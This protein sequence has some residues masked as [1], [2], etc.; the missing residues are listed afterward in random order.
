MPVSNFI[1]TNYSSNGSI[2]LPGNAQNVEV[3][4]WGSKGANGA[5]S[6]GSGGSGRYM[7]VTLPNYTARTLSFN[8]DKNGGSGGNG[9][10]WSETIAV[11]S[12]CN[13]TSNISANW[14]SNGVLKVNGAGNANI[15]INQSTNDSPNTAG[16]SFTNAS[17]NSNFNSSSANFTFN[18]GNFSDSAR[19]QSGDVQFNIQGL[20]KPLQRFN[21]NQ[22]LKLRDGDGNDTNTSFCIG[23]INQKTYS[24]DCSY[25]VTNNYSGYDGGQGGKSA[26]LGDSIAGDYIA[27][28]GGGGGGGGGNSKGG[29]GGN[30]SNAGAPGNSNI[31]QNINGDGNGGSNSAYGGGGG[32]GAGISPGGAG[33][34]GGSPSPTGG[35]GGTGGSSAYD[36]SYC[37]LSTHNTTNQANPKATLKYKLITP[38]INS[39]SVNKTTMINNGTDSITLKWQTTDAIDVDLKGNS[40]DPVYGNSYVD[41]AVDNTSG[42]V[43]Q[44]T[45]DITY[46]LR[47]CSYGNVCTTA[48]VAITVY[49]VPTLDFSVD[50]TSIINGSGQTATL[51]WAITGDG[52]VAQIDQGIGSI[53]QT[54]VQ[55]VQPGATT[56]YTLSLTS[57]GGDLTETIT[58]T[59]YNPPQLVF[60]GPTGINYG[61]SYDFLIKT[62]FANGGSQVEMR[63][64]YFNAD[65]TPANSYT[66]T[67]INTG[68]D[69]S[70]EAQTGFREFEFTPNITWT[71][72]GPYR[73]DFFASASG[74]GGSINDSKSYMV[75]IDRTPNPFTIPP[76]PDEPPEEDP[77]VSPDDTKSGFIGSPVILIDD[78]DIPVEISAD[79]PIQVRFD[80]DDPDVDASWKNLRQYNL[81]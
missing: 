39:F 46:T 34:G 7:K 66:T 25:N 15:T 40:E 18:N 32:G 44:P 74:D 73:V 5:Q 38:E 79:E 62:M 58:L 55:V 27:I 4:L 68:A 2:N 48:S 72:L 31:G 1:T 41:V 19:F 23:T 6:A 35:G 78:I 45:D 67:I 65:G 71:D 43:R 22:C 29:T 21:N 56:D 81:P 42:L 52:V 16:T 70:A 50:P 8:F 12:T 59:V 57:L 47:A 33:G 63:E 11:P 51:S 17:I 64:Y 30:G 49:Q 80:P 61:L 14:S 3:Q 76:N 28:A 24:Y 75:N 53:L 69:A 36:G 10:S 20:Q 60:N 9:G 77:V 26:R 13:A 54:G 37:S